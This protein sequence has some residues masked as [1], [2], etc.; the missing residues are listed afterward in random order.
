VRW[1]LALALAILAGAAG[2]A[3]AQDAPGVDYDVSNERWNGLSTLDALA[4]GMGLEVVQRSEL[5]WNDLE[6]GDI[7]FL[8]YPTC[9][10]RCTSA[11]N[12]A[13]LITFLRNGGRVLLADDFG[14]ADEALGALGIV[15]GPGGAARAETFWDAQ[16]FA[17]VAF[18]VDR[19]HPL[20]E[21]VDELT[22]NHPSVWRAMRGGPEAVIGF[23]DGSTVVA[24]VNMLDG[25]LVALSDPSVLI[26]RMLEFP[27][28]L[29]F[30]VNTVRWLERPYETQ[31]LVIMTG[32]ISLYGT[33]SRMLGDDAQAGGVTGTLNDFNGWL[34]NLNLWAMSETTMRV[35]GI[36]I[37]GLVA[38]LALI[39]LPR[40]RK[41]TLDGSWTR[42]R[43]GGTIKTAEQMMGELDRG[44]RRVSY[45]VPAAVLRDSINVRLARVVGVPDPLFGMSESS[46][47]G[48]L[49]ERAPGAVSALRAIYPQ[50]RALPTRAQASSPWQSPFVPQR[51]FEAL[52]AAAA[53]LYR[54]L[55]E[56]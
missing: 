8:L 36:S 13:H 6:R 2:P 22:T 16:P 11:V 21:N 25:R 10:E 26:N 39:V 12:Q 23:G 19:H 35:V 53:H 1:R 55:G 18:P 32:E 31:R 5:Q 51:D 29:A 3:A 45:A 56:S 20:A 50:L 49:A 28:N 40:A 47:F 27:G 30:A 52:G 14:K 7:L 15:R 38:L 48:A 17:P 46:L 9:G 42:A 44:G 37:A 41:S 43:G 54:S 34:D 33:P 4:R 24:A